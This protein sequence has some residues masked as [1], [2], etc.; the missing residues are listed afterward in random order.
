MPSEIKIHQT[1]PIIQKKMKTRKSSSVKL[2]S[3]HAWIFRP[4]GGEMPSSK[5]AID[6]YTLATILTPFPHMVNRMPV[7]P[8]EL[9]ELARRHPCHFL[10]LVCP[11]KPATHRINHNCASLS[12]NS[13]S[14]FLSS[15]SDFMSPFPL[16][17]PAKRRIRFRAALR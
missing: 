17:I 2:W 4:G 14:Y 1:M 12:H 6:W 7:R 11:Y 5:G 10:E 16:N 8:T 9:L 13:R 3:S 15:I